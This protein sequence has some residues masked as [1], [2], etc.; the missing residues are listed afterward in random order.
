MIMNPTLPMLR[1]HFTLAVLMVAAF[2]SGA[3][4]PPQRDN[5]ASNNLL[6]ENPRLRQL[7]ADANRASG[8][9][10]ILRLAEA[11]VDP[12]VIQKYVESSGR[13]YDLDAEQII[14]LHQRGVNGEVI[15]AM[16]RRRTPSETAVTAPAPS[17]VAPTVIA[18]AAP[19]AAPVS[20]VTYLRASSRQT[21]FAYRPLYVSACP[22]DLAA[23]GFFGYG[24]FSSVYCR[25]SYWH[26]RPA[27]WS[28][29]RADGCW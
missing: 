7:L 23:P 14:R 19:A 15:S 2:I 8:P 17:T 11:G 21:R 12:V 6:S 10:E 9:E 3:N 29:F 26:Y 5:A 24:G 28:D 22:C 1:I 13:R 16:I 18:I 27:W 25:P 20:T 4:P